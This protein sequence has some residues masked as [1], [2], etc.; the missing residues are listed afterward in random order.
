AATVISFRFFRT[1]F[2]AVDDF[3]TSHRRLIFV[4]AGYIGGTCVLQ[5]NNSGGSANSNDRVAKACTQTSATLSTKK[6]GKSRKICSLALSVLTGDTRRIG[7]ARRRK[8]FILTHQAR[9]HSA[10][11]FF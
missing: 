3:A 5:Q 9:L 4:D 11:R 2:V 1:A 8:N 7:G 6:A 10:R